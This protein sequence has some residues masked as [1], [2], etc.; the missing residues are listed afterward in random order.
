MDYRELERLD[1]KDNIFL[2]GD[3]ETGKRYIKKIVSSYGLEIYKKLQDKGFKG[4]AKL[5]EIIPLEDDKVILIEEY[6]DGFTLQYFL[7]KG[8]RFTEDEV[9]RILSD[10]CEILAPIHSCKPCII[11]R[12]IKPSNIMLTKSGEVKLIDFNASKIYT[13]GKCEDTILM[14][15]I[16]Y[17]APEQYGFSQTHITADVYSLGVLANVLLT[18]EFPNVIQYEGEIKGI[19]KKCIKMD[20]QQRYKRVSEI[21][22]ALPKIDAKEDTGG[23]KKRKNKRYIPS[24]CKYLPPG[25]RTLRIWKM[26]VALFMYSTLVA[27]YFFEENTQTPGDIVS[28]WIL[29]IFTMVCIFIV[30]NY[31]GIR[32]K[33]PFNSNNSVLIR[34]GGILIVCIALMLIFMIIVTIVQLALA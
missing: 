28:T 24:F 7:D 20:S 21:K 14:G 27:G 17:A 29:F 15:T 34:I 23:K 25:F 3:N 1:D 30:F 19:I 33:M 13:K 12:D 31:L 6:I 9:V 5:Y 18:G 10:L 32:D 16:G 11:H 2:I 4:L 22:E 8:R 26:L